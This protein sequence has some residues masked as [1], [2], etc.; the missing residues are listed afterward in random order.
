MPTKLHTSSL[1]PAAGIIFHSQKY[2]SSAQHS[3]GD[4]DGVEEMAFELP[5]HFTPGSLATNLLRGVA[6]VPVLAVVAAVAV[7]VRKQHLHTALNPLT[8]EQRELLQAFREGRLK[9]VETEARPPPAKPGASILEMMN[10]GKPT[11]PQAGAPTGRPSI[12]D[13]A[14]GRAT[15]SST[16]PPPPAA[17]MPGSEPAPGSPER[18]AMY[19]PYPRPQPAWVTAPERPP[20]EFAR[21]P[22]NPMEIGQ[23][24]GAYFS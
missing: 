3:I 11:Q 5:P 9:P 24:R 13:M 15:G 1:R 8:A 2:Q 6:S 7:I 21:P 14:T 12:A 10:A 19:A 18:F 17:S 16:A 4:G 22:L 20:P 23:Q